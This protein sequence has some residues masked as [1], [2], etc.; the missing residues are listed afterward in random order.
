MSDVDELGGFVIPPELQA[1]CELAL[2][3]PVYPPLPPGAV[4]LP[5]LGLISPIIL[6]AKKLEARTVLPEEPEEAQDG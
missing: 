5:A 1:E 4:V 6:P 2:S 3:M